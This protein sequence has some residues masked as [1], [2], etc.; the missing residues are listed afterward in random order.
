MLADQ[1]I[2]VA[3]PCASQPEFMAAT[4]ALGEKNRASRSVMVFVGQIN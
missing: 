2:V 3:S 1:Y 4:G